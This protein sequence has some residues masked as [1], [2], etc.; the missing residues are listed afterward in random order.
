MNKIKTPDKFVK[1]EK[2]IAACEVLNN[3]QH[4]LIYG[5]SRSGKTTIIIRN[6]VLRAMMT[7]SRHLVGRFRFNHAKTSLWYDTIPKVMRMEFPGVAYHMNKSD[8]FM[9]IPVD[10][11]AGGGQSEIWLGGFDDK[12]RVEKILGNEYSTMFLNECSQIKYDAVTLLRTRLAE[13][14]GLRL[15]AYYDCNPSGKAHW[16]YQEFIKG[17]IPGTKEKSILDTGYMTINPYDNAVNLPEEYFNI[18]KSLPKRQRE[19]F[20]DGLFLQ[21]VDGALWTDQMCS[22]AR[23]KVPGELIKVVVAVDPAVSNN[24]DSDETGI[25]VCGLDENKQGVVIED[26]TLKA[27][28]RVWAQRAVNAYH[29]HDANEIVVEV[30]QGGDLVEDVL[31]NI[32]KS[33][34]VVKVRASKGKFARA[35][36]ISALYE[37]ED[38][39]HLPGLDDLESQITEYVPMN[40]KESPGR[41]DAL[42]WGLTRLMVKKAAQIHIG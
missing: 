8:W 29:K 36:P 16:T 3:H 12:E 41:L 39:A 37:S 14:S 24:P 15:R 35:E 5:G 40:S 23:A 38:V 30:N 11:K 27:S 28:T 42:V 34:K 25:V 10:A 7:P 20:L 19:R 31:K 18:L 32:D 21:D 6:I 33:I 22:D 13:N 9:T 26:L 17:L 2:Q 1:T 4:S